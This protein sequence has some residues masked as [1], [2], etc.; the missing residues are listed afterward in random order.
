[1][2][3]NWTK[4]RY[5]RS[6]NNLRLWNENP[7]LDPLDIYYTTKDYVDGMFRNEN[8]RDDFVNLAKSI[9]DNGF[10]SLDPVVVWRNEKGQYVVAEGNRRVAVL[11]LL[12]EPQK[13]PK[14]IRR[15]FIAFSS[16]IDKSQYEKISVCVAPS[17]EAC[18]WYINQRHEAK[19]TQKRWGRENYMLWI[20]NLYIRFGKDI[21][22][23][24]SFTG[25]AEGDII[26]IICV[27][28]LKEKLTCELANKLTKEELEQMRSPVFPITTFERVVNNPLA[29]DF[30]KMSFEGLQVKVKAN[31]DSFLNAFAV[32]L[33]RLMLPRTDEEYL[34]S[35]KLNTSDAIGEMLQ[36]LP[37]V[38]EGDCEFS[39][40]DNN[41]P[42][43]NNQNQ[44]THKDSKDNKSGKNTDIEINNPNRAHLIP[45]ELEIV[46]NDYR[47]KTLFEELKKLSGRTYPNVSCASLRVFL[48]ISVRNYIQD[49]GWKDELVRQ[50]NGKDFEKIELSTRLNYLST[51]ILGKKI[52]DIL[53]KL[54]NPQN[55]FSINTLNRYIHSNETYIIDRVFVN[56]FWNFMQPLLNE[57]SGISE[58]R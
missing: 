10:L 28:N 48:D 17:F 25:A 19:S 40:G 27:L 29:K 12:Q 11:K 23:I 58:I 24:K 49:K 21:N 42:L 33:H 30:F 7:R 6:V 53:L 51:K 41:E 32:L 47:L 13:A 50:N 45:K 3:N 54:I 5:S 14:S 1:M 34:D 31:Y 38:N 39:W 52:K 44:H 20:S 57:I 43:S 46:T 8:D 37:K 4:K 22:R 55:E 16:K 56:R 9:V 35:R 36:Q 18:I 26:K 15:V 2:D